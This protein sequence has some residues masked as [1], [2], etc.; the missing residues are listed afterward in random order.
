MRIKNKAHRE[1]ILRCPCVVCYLLN[2]TQISITEGHHIKH[3]PD[4]T[5]LKMG[6]EKADDKYMI[7][8]CQKTHHWN[9]VHVT[10]SREEFESIAGDE[11]YLWKVTNE[12]LIPMYG[13]D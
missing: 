10:M 8:L 6:D 5:I 12:I 1:A 13:G 11:P 7:P 2:R 3:L 9:G 4:G